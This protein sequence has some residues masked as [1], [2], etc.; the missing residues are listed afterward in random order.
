MFCLCN[1]S[2]PL[3]SCSCGSAQVLVGL[4]KLVEGS[5]LGVPKAQI[6]LCE[7]KRL[8]S[9]SRLTLCVKQRVG[10]VVIWEGWARRAIH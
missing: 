7:S 6:L 8:F 3:R 5:V 9:L 4:M 1:L 10:L 2:V